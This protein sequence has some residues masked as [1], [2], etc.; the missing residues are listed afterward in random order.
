MT[1]TLT[2]IAILLRDAAAKAKP[3]I[4]PVTTARIAAGGSWHVCLMAVGAGDLC[5]AAPDLLDGACVEVNIG[6]LCRL[7]GI[8]P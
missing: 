7:A 6:D 4:G 1:A 3:A 8:D 5:H 2:E